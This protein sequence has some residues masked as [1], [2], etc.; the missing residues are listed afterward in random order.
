MP[1]GW[2]S[3]R[4]PRGNTRASEAAFTIIDVALAAREMSLDDFMAK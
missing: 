2:Q 4:I 3:G 1:V